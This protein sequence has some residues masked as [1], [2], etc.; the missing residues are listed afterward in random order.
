MTD[1]VACE[2]CVGCSLCTQTLALQH[3]PLTICAC[4][5]IMHVGTQLQV[6]HA[7]PTTTHES[8]FVATL[9]FSTSPTG[10]RAIQDGR[11]GRP[12]ACSHAAV[13]NLCGAPATSSSAACYQDATYRM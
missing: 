5:L 8:G 4:F 2:A 9:V 13:H 10:H 1:H 11:C 7:L 3:M 6:R 12:V